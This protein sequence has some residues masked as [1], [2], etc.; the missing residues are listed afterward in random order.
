MFVDLVVYRFFLRHGFFSF[1][2]GNCVLEG[3]CHCL[4][5]AQLPIRHRGERRR[6][7]ERKN[8]IGLLS[9]AFNL[10]RPPYHIIRL[11]TLYTYKGYELPLNKKRQALT[12]SQNAFQNL[13]LRN[14]QLLGQPHLQKCCQLGEFSAV[15][16]D[17]VAL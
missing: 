12:Y 11:T 1:L 17:L 8:S 7:R 5:A 13:L 6:L 2:V 4:L 16:Y 15:G 10:N 3:V 14:L 9:V